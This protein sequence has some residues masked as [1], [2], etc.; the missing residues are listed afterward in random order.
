MERLGRRTDVL[1]KTRLSRV[2]METCEPSARNANA[3]SSAIGPEPMIAIWCRRCRE[4]EQ[5]LV[6][7]NTMLR[8]PVD[9]HR[10]SAG[11]CRND[12]RIGGKFTDRAV[13]LVSPAMRRGSTKRAYPCMNVRFLVCFTWCVSSSRK[14][15]RLWRTFAN[16]AAESG[17][18][19]LLAWLSWISDFDGIH[20]TFV[21]SPPTACDSIRATSRPS[22]AR[23][24]RDGKTAR[25]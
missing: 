11:T 16:A 24:N 3:I 14:S 21:Q 6:R 12:D 10:R 9:L 13:V 8:Q 25:S 4:V 19:P 23:S 17:S 22:C 1:L 5:I 2:A 18:S 15:S 20:P 7:Q